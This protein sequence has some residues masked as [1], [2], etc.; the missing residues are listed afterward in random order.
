MKCTFARQGSN[1]TTTHLS[2]E[3]GGPT[4]QIFSSLHPQLLRSL[5]LHQCSLLPAL[6]CISTGRCWHAA[7]SSTA[8]P[9]HSSTAPAPLKAQ[10]Q[11]TC[12]TG[13]DTQTQQRTTAWIP[14]ESRARRLVLPMMTLGAGNTSFCRFSGIQVF[15]GVTLR[16]N[17]VLPS[18]HLLQ[19]LRG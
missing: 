6:G 13:V 9:R 8:A 14:E 3:L 11:A 5:M 1:S 17:I 10:A 4:G 15:K 18:P 19:L 7:A 16:D 2:S 12:S